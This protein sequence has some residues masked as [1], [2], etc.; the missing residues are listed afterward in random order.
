MGP[1]GPADAGHNGRSI[2][3]KG[4]CSGE[5]VA[6]QLL[7]SFGAIVWPIDLLLSAAHVSFGLLI[8][9]R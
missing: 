6:A 2:T 7:P 3:V 5:M 9:K 8:S 4:H 1:E